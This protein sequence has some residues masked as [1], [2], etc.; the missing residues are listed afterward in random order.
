VLC[1]ARRL[2]R[3]IF[4]MRS[5]RLAQDKLVVVCAVVV[6]DG[7]IDGDGKSAEVIDIQSYL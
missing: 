6:E 2:L 1:L 5:L 7:R 4:N 3:D